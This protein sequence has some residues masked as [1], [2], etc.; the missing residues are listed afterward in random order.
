M[1][2]WDFANKLIELFGTQGILW[3]LLLSPFIWWVYLNWNIFL[4]P[5][6]EN[7]EERT[8]RR[9]DLEARRRWIENR[10]FENRYLD[11]LSR[12]LDWLA[13]HLTHDADKMI[14]RTTPES[15]TGRLFTTN[16]FTEGSYD[17]TLRIAL[18][19][20]IFSFIFAWIA[21]AEGIFSGIQL[22]PDKESNPIQYLPLYAAVFFLIIWLS[23][24]GI[25]KEIKVGKWRGIFFITFCFVYTLI[26]VVIGGGA[27]IMAIALV[28]IAVHLTG[29][30]A[31]TAVVTSAIIAVVTP[32]IIPTDG[33]TIFIAF[34]AAVIFSYVFGL[35]AD[36][37][38]EKP[39]S[40]NS[41]LI[42]WLSYN[43]FAV[44]LL[45][46]GMVWATPHLNQSDILLLPLFLGILP[47]A[48]AA[49]DWLS[50]GFTRGLL[51]NIRHGHHTGG[52]ALLWVGLDILLALFFLFAIA[53]LTTLLLAGINA[54]SLA[55]D[56]KAIMDLI[57][58]F[59]GLKENP[60]ALE[61]S[62]IHFMMLSTL[63]PT[64][65][66]FIIAGFALVLVMPSWLRKW[67]LSQWNER[68][69]ANYVAFFYISFIPIL[70]L[71]GPLMLLWGLWELLTAWGGYVGWGLLAWMRDI[72]GLIDPSF[73][74]G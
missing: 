2:F 40:S 56:G 24:K 64:L 10:S 33:S 41:I 30:V 36:K 25:K 42:Y 71:I 72:A 6:P 32:A 3:L 45:V 22:L 57:S 66:H 44:I 38:K 63:I 73:T 55:V 16:P 18:V 49:M 35:F 34:T 51:Y 67:V 14:E 19:Y 39:G 20:P 31:V 12:G 69:D 4:K 47:L 7:E 15:R 68:G 74:P 26:F 37:I 28:A 62:W 48:N 5:L 58:L 1:T 60:G 70:G 65:L 29:T 9:N 52:M 43:I 13:E 53:S 11:L 23:V 27:M 54:I 17:L 50:L 46:S 59:D 61:Y 8:Q 21:G